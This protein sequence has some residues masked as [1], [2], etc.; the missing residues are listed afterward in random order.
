[1]FQNHGFFIQGI[2]VGD[3][4]DLLVVFSGF[5]I[6]AGCL[7][8]AE[9]DLSVT[10]Q[11]TDGQ[12]DRFKEEMTAGIDP[13]VIPG[14]KDDAQRIQVTP[15]D[16]SFNNVLFHRNNIGVHGFRDSGFTV[17]TQSHEAL[18]MLRLLN[19]LRKNLDLTVHC[20]EKNH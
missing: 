5:E 15:H 9:Q 16:F 7:N 18:S 14:I 4:A 13:F 1:V 6:A 3:N 12:V 20:S 10:P 2:N 11:F 19:R 8:Q 17:S